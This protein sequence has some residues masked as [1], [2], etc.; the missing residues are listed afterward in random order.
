MSSL[1]VAGITLVVMIGFMRVVYGVITKAAEKNDIW[2]EEQRRKRQMA[3][4]G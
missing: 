2:K 4:E 1:M 3:K